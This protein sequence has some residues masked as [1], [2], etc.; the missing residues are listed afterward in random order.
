MCL[1]TTK[2][3]NIVLRKEF[4][5]YLLDEH[6]L[7]SSSEESLIADFVELLLINFEGRVTSSVLRLL[8]VECTLDD[9][10]P[11]RFDRRR[12]FNFIL[13]SISSASASKRSCLAVIKTKTALPSPDFFLATIKPC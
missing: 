3:V 7:L 9:E 6:D 12:T 4:S 2:Q 8:I 10:G 13:I 5:K 11:L 1:I